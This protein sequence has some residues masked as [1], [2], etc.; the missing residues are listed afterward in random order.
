MTFYYNGYLVEAIGPV[1]RISGGYIRK[2]RIV[3][4][5]DYLSGYEFNAVV[6]FNGKP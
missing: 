1:K 5:D 4:C 6:G 2:V 3:G